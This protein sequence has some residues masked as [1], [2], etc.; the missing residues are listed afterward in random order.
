MSGGYF[1]YRDGDLCEEI[2][3]TGPTLMGGA[4]YKDNIKKA[5]HRN[6]LG[7]KE[8]SELVYDVMCLL[9]EY[10][11]YQES[12]T[13]RES[14]LAAKKQFKKKWFSTSRHE[15]LQKQLSYA[16]AS[17]DEAAAEAK[18]SLKEAFDEK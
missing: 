17:I 1:S 5:I 9:R 4:F 2:F 7:D 14:Y 8:I 10:D 11:Y 16:L 18:V 3:G 13:S 6:P 12:D 15:R